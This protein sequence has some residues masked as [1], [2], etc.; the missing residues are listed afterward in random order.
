MKKELY[1]RVGILED[2]GMI[3]QKVACYSREIVDLILSQIRE[4]SQEKLEV[5]ITHLAMAGK[6]AEEG[7][8]ENPIDGAILEA[9][10]SETVY[11]EAIELRDKILSRTNIV[12]PETE[13]D[14]LSVHLCN[15]LL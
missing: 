6:R 11:P 8:E 4:V 3:S 9:M 14:F 15:L 1:E 10:K 7:I 12:F 13:R 2:N 5:L